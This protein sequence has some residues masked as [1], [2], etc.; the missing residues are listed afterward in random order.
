M[1]SLSSHNCSMRRTK[2]WLRRSRMS[3][4]SYS[5]FCS[6]SRAAALELCVLEPLP[7]RMDARAEVTDCR[8]MMV[9]AEG[10]QHNLSRHEVA[11]ISDRDAETRRGR[12]QRPGVLSPN[13]HHLFLAVYSLS[14]NRLVN[15]QKRLRLSAPRMV[16][17]T[18]NGFHPSNS[19]SRPQTDMMLLWPG[20]RRSRWDLRG[21][22]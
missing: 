10:K 8:F 3:S 11:R 7:F 18:L 16:M 13:H 22:N 5:F 15:V 6:R 2:L 20:R 9:G 4:A 14:R 12:A 21:M 1:T 19:H 17:T